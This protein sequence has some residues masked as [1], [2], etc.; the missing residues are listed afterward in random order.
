[1]LQVIREKFTGGFA[2]AILALIGVPFLFFGI[3][4]DFIGTS[5]AA[6]VN[7]EDIT[8]GQLELS[9]QQQLQQNPQLAQLPVEYRAQYRER[10]LDSLVRQR[11][12]DQYLANAGYRISDAQVTAAVQ[13]IPDFHVDGVFD[14]DTYLS[15]LAQNG[16]D[17][18]QFEESQRNGMRQDQLQ[19]AVGATAIVTPAE[20]RRYLNLVAEQR[21]VSLA[22]FT[23]DGVAEDFE[24]AADQITAFYDDNTTLFL[25]SESADIEFIEIRRDEVSTAVDISEDVL[26]EYYEDSKSR[27]L[28]DEERQ[29]RHILI[30][31][32]DDD[33]AAEATAADILAR[34]QA[35]ESFEALATE[36]SKDGGTAS[37]GGD[38]GTLTRSQLPGDL[39]GAIFSMQEGAVEGPIRSEFGFHIIRLDQIFERGPLPLDQ[40]RGELLSE[41]RDRE[42]DEA[43]RALE[44]RMSDAY[45][46]TSDL[47]VISAAIGIDV[48]SASNFT[49]AGGEPF[50]SNQVAIDAVFSEGVLTGGE[51]SEI[52]ELD[53]NSVA[54]FKVAQYREASRQPLEE[55]SDL[56]VAEMR[57]QE[58]DRKIV[59][60][61][62]QLLAALDAGEDFGTAAEAASATVE[63]PKLIGRQD[64]EVD[65]AVLF[66]V[67]AASKPEQNS[68]VIGQISNV[69]GGYTV[70]S[71]DAVLPGR[72][73]SI[74]LADRDAGKLQLAQQA[75]NADFVSFVQAL[76]DNADIII[77]G[78]AVAGTTDL[79]Q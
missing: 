32:D 66:Q 29:A 59:A 58:A 72:P 62:E 71:L 64:E 73:E 44:R 52:V 76:Y 13:R 74:P 60:Q 15:L 53:A 67:F 38:L 4:Y 24:V 37:N 77:N 10:V 61:V 55:V 57:A 39:G 40:V 17:P 43:F 79:F 41:L 3:N 36:F 68:P 11:L 12:I 1:M 47:Q 27:Y 78:D 30:L 75:G 25:T 63:N 46:D 7:G 22:T 18:T 5:F 20:Y 33:A 21:L 70:F 51:I 56:I 48:Q 45:F 16:Y 49:R 31:F 23:T 50:G 42:A 2:I 54:I 9:Y 6:K 28:Q 26:Q 69:G 65:Q 8:S 19:R 14:K 34:V 35:G